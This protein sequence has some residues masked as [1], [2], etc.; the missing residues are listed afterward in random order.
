MP[1]ITDIR[2][3]SEISGGVLHDSIGYPVLA[4]LSLIEGEI[5]LLSANV[6]IDETFS[7]DKSC[8][9]KL[10]VDQVE[11]TGDVSMGKDYQAFYEVHGENGSILVSKAYS[12]DDQFEAKIIETTPHENFFYSVT[13][14]NQIENFLLSFIDNINQNTNDGGYKNNFYH[15]SLRL[16]IA[17]DNII[18]GATF[19]YD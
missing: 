2:L 15:T 6:T 14:S 5:S 12:V 10:K 19:S 1:A 17:I 4:A 16:R 8:C 18:E 11:V 3:N 7:I 13:K 9:F